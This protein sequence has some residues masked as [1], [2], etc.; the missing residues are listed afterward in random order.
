M[1]GVGGFA[2]DTILF[3]TTLKPFEP[4]VAEYR[5]AL[6]QGKGNIE[7]KAGLT[8]RWAFKPL[9]DSKGWSLDYRSMREV[10][11]TVPF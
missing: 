5:F 11:K 8:Y 4:D 2:A 1:I 9:A 6:P 7:I 3:D 10:S